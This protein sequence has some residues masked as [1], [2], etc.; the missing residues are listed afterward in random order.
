M[1]KIVLGKRPESF[2]HPIKFPCHDGTEGVM[3]VLY[4]YRT[5][6]EFGAFID[7]WVREQKMKLDAEK[8]K[9]DA[10]RQKALEAGDA[11]VEP[12][13]TNE[14]LRQAQAKT[15]ADYIQRIVVG[16]NLEVEF[17]P[18]TVLQLCDE[19]PGAAT[20][21]MDRY[22]GAITEGRLGN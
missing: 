5:V 6:T 16:W 19:F 15:N 2:K 12:E 7:V 8:A 9:A 4:K 20:E 10:A 11:Y 13:V 21:I 18:D 22:R 1:A 14:E 17:T 3:E